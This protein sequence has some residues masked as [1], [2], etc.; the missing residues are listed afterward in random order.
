MLKQTLLFTLFFITIIGAKAQVNNNI[1]IVRDTFGVAHIFGKTDADVVYGLSYA[2]CED[3]FKNMQK[4]VALAKHKLGL[5]EGKNGAAVDYYNQ[6]L[7]V[8]KTVDEAYETQLSQKFRLLLDNYA[9][10]INAYAASH[11]NEIILQQLF[12]VT[13]RDVIKGFYTILTGMVGTA[14]ALKSCMENKADSFI[15]NAGRGSNSFALAANRSTDASTMLVINPHVPLEGMLSWWE[16]HVSSE[17]GWNFHGS[18]FPLMMGPAMGAGD[19]LGWGVTFNWP[20]YVD[21]YRMEI[22]PSNKNEYKFDGTYIPF[23]RNKASLKVK[24]GAVKLALKKEVLWCK[25]GPAMRTKHGVFALRY[26]VIGNIKA[27]E[28]WF[29]MS[30]AN[31]FDEFKATLQMHSIPLFNFVYADADNNIAH[32]F[33]GMLPKRT[34]QYNWQRILPGNTSATLWNNFI[35]IN[36]MPRT[37]NP[38]CGFVY[39]TNNTPWR[40][41]CDAENIDSTKYDNLSAW[42]WNRPNGRDY[43]LRELIDAKDKHSFDDVKAIKFDNTYCQWNNGI[44]KSMLPVMQLNLAKYPDI[45]EAVMVMREWD[46]TSHID[47]KNIA[48]VLHTFSEIGLLTNAAYNEMETGFKFNEVQ[49]VKCI[50]IAQ[51]SLLNN[52]N[53][54]T[55]TLGQVQVV[56]RGKLEYPMPGSPDQL[57]PSYDEKIKGGKFKIENGDT[58]TMI[59]KF[60]KKLGNCYQTQMP[61]GASSNPASKHYTDQMKMYSTHKTKTIS[62]NKLDIIPFAERIYMPK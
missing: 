34:A 62:L 31:N 7:R 33:N 52:F 59:V 30:H 51:K 37:I 53:T 18:F 22:N 19:K 58:Y 27:A 15:F 5:I 23:E 20:D 49:L 56:K 55:P 44:R 50:R 42:F 29:A 57:A 9:A 11:H 8:D 38:Q 24:L 25:Y 48:M 32:F 13:G 28:Q 60:N 46:Y 12:P 4:C 61:F 1:S 43:R 16:A 21:V 3:D 40:N 47:N 41:T 17:E 6:L 54:L 36:D 35:P 26:N 2:H 39:N 10:G 45:K 14:D